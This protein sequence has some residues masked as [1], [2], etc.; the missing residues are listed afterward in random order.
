MAIKGAEGVVVNIISTLQAHL[1]AEL[2]LISSEMGDGISIPDVAAGDYYDWE[3]DISAYVAN[4]PSITVNAKSSDILQITSVTNS[5]GVDQSIHHVDTSVHLK[6]TG[7]VT[8]S[9]LKKQCLRYER[10]I[11]RVLLIKYPT[12]P[13]GGVETVFFCKPGGPITYI[14][15]DQADQEGGQYVRSARIPFAVQVYE[16]L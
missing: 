7:N 6:S 3:I 11:V 1:G 12:L 10:A 15:V 2:T 16:N 4:S 9:V 13:T 14:D 8:A 5:P